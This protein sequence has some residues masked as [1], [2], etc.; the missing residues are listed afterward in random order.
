M[1]VLMFKKIVNW[2]RGKSS[3]NAGHV[4]Y[5][6]LNT[7]QGIFY[8]IGFTTMAS[9][10]ARMYFS[11]HGDERL[12]E[13]ELLFAYHPKARELEQV[14]LEHFDQRRAFG[15]YSNDPFKPLAGRGQSELFWEDV[16]GL[17]D[18]L[19]GDTQER[20]Q[21]QKKQRG[22][23]MAGFLLIL[24]GLALAPFTYGLT[25]TLVAGGFI[26]ITNSKRQHY[27]L[28]NRPTHTKE[29][30]KIIDTLVRSQRN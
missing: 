24:I 17:D 26:G 15:R 16:L 3:A 2:L 30:Q 8:K 11:G 1:C 23:V 20:A 19:Y 10:T 5:A 7:P 6:R 27:P 9:L 21:H 12:I 22:H 13:R 25:L 28:P 4:Y 14:L 18:E 29:I